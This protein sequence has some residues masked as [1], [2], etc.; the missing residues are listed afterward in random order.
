MDTMFADASPN[1]QEA[2]VNVNITDHTLYK[3]M[4]R[5][6]SKLNVLVRRLAM[7]QDVR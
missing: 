2:G 4:Q 5:A 7:I 6:L 1:T 3:A